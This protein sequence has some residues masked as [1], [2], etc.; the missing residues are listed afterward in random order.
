MRVAMISICALCAATAAARPVISLNLD[1]AAMP[2]QY[3]AGAQ[4]GVAAAG[5]EAP[6]SRSRSG[7]QAYGG[8]NHGFTE[9]FS[10]TCAAKTSTPTSCPMPT[11]RAYDHHD[12]E[13]TVVQKLYLVNNNGVK[14][15]TT[16]TYASIN[17]NLRSE[18]LLTFD[19]ADNSGNKAQQVVFAMI[20]DDKIA[21]VITPR[22]PNPHTIEA[23]N[24]DNVG[25]STTH[26]NFWLLPNNN[27]ANDNYDGN[28]EAELKVAI[29][30]PN[31]ATPSVYVQG[32]NPQIKLDSHVIGDWNVVYSVHD[33][34]GM[35]GANGQD[36]AVQLSAKVSVTDTVAPIL[37]AKKHSCKFE[38]GVRDA[39]FIKEVTA[40]TKEEC[41]NKCETQQWTRKVGTAAQLNEAAC[42]YFVFQSAT[43][44]CQFLSKDARAA[45]LTVVAGAVGGYPVQSSDANVEECSAITAVPADKGARCIDFHD[46]LMSS[47]SLSESA[48]ATQVVT[49][50]TAN[51]KVVGSYP[52]KYNCKDLS[53]NAAAQVTRTVQ[54]KDT[55]NPV[56]VI[57]TGDPAH[58]VQKANIDDLYVVQHSAGNTNHTAHVQRLMTKKSA[59]VS[60][61][62]CTDS[63]T[64][65]LTNA[66]V[67]TVHKGPGG[68]AGTVLP[69]FTTSQLM[70]PSTYHIKYTC[71]DASSNSVSKCR[72]IKVEDA[73]KPIVTVIGFD[74]K[75][76]E[77]TTDGQYIDEGATCSDQVDGNIP[78]NVEVG[79]DVVRLEVPKTYT[80]KY[81]CKDSQGN[82]AEPAYRKVVVRDTTCPTCTIQGDASITR[83]A[84][85]PYVDAGATCTD[86]LD[87]TLTARDT[88]SNVNVETTGTYFVTYSATDHA[89]NGFGVARPAGIT[90]QCL[91]YVR[92]VT[93]KDTLRP[94]IALRYNGA[95]I[96]TS[97][98]T[99]KGS[100]GQANPA[101]VSATN[102][103]FMESGAANNWLAAGALSAVAGVLVATVGA[104]RQAV[105]AVPV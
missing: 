54:V 47:G 97:D 86:S 104:R 9:N 34:A 35:F 28:L 50:G 65:D 62:H 78:E 101:G 98:A 92:T 88:V 71:T 48:L 60:G 84:S 96:H 67:V 24:R 64:G 79:G 38:T 63:C 6:M 30:A 66:V 73:K 61:Y 74:L 70:Q 22:M 37:Y 77:A 56:L 80:V 25:Q 105:T 39:G 87:G 81:T 91:S 59:T 83:E 99:D 94:V 23:C 85:F 57:T 102:P 100:N 76:F 72:T 11:A 43:N 4:G 36:N 68:C 19:A 75:T 46:S 93:V 12:G 31:S 18:W 55:T 44:K 42:A 95:L 45:P 89:N 33:H 32:T 16:E 29:T 90:T 7:T 5:A 3:A 41:C 53:N 49:V 14:G 21:P 2:V 82:Q 51:T 40:T 58:P 27:P 103:H 1:E 26:S 52:I 17:Y 13:L 15:S 8:G 10:K 69:T 20:L